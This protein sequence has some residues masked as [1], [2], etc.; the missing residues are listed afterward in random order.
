MFSSNIKNLKIY[1]P[2]KL[3]FFRNNECCNLSAI[4]IY[5]YINIYTYT[6]SEQNKKKGKVITKM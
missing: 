4:Y 1:A 2:M 6:N 5:A 3:Y